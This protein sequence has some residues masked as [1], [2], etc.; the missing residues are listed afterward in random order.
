[1]KFS[2][3]QPRYRRRFLTRT[4][5]LLPRLVQLPQDQRHDSVLFSSWETLCHGLCLKSA[6]EVGASHEGQHLAVSRAREVMIPVDSTSA[7]P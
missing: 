1:V 2:R 3:R 6:S 5:F 4:Q 7:A